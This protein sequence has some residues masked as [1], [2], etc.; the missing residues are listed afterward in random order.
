MS[1]DIFDYMVIASLNQW[2]IWLNSG[3]LAKKGLFLIFLFVVFCLNF[4]VLI[5][6]L[7]MVLHV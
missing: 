7:I 2:I 6:S 4:M 1:I 5:V 3:F